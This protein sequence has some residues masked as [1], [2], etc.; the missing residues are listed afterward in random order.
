MAPSSVLPGVLRSG[1]SRDAARPRTTSSSTASTRSSSAA[2]TAVS[3]EPTSSAQSGRSTSRRSSRV[4]SRLFS[5]FGAKRELIRG[6]R[7]HHGRAVPPERAP[8]HR[9]TRR[10]YRQRHGR[11]GHDHRCGLYSNGQR[12][13]LIMSNRRDE[14]APP[15]LRGRRQ[16]LVDRVVAFARVRH[17]GHGSQLRLARPHG[18][19]QHRRGLHVH[20]RTP[21][22]ERGLADVHVQRSRSRAP[23]SPIP[24]LEDRV[25]IS[26]GFRNSTARRA[27][28]RRSS[29][30]P[31]AR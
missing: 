20:P 19:H 10:Q 28:A 2:E 12:S 27:S 13:W 26:D 21:A 22:L 16:H 25:L 6:C 7:R 3:L 11:H 15:H 1:R 4:V 9:R 5:T 18:R 17:R 31:R 24:T 29:S 14:R 30:L 23:S 8:Q